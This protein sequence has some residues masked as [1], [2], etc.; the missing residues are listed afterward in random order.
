MPLLPDH[1]HVPVIA[2]IPISSEACIK[3]HRSSSC[4][5]TERPLFEVKKKGRP[6][7]QCP[8]CREL[9]Q[10]KRVHSKCTCTPHQPSVDKV[11]IPAARPDRKREW[12][13]AESV[14][15]DTDADPFRSPSVHA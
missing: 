11:P 13:A 9:R 12:I 15:Q 3:G 1:R 14:G 6:V 8:K 4:H 2:G 5:H 7:S 10:A